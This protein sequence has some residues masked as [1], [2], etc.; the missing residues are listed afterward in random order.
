MAKWP[1]KNIY[2]KYVTSLTL[3]P[4]GIFSYKILGRF[5]FIQETDIIDL[6]K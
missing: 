6:I 2:Q 5:G 3:D 1:S 4:N